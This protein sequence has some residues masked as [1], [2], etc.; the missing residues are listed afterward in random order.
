V[1]TLVRQLKACES[2]VILKI[3]D[4]AATNETQLYRSTYFDLKLCRIDAKGKSQCLTI[5]RSSRMSLRKSAMAAL[6]A[7]SLVVVPSVAFAAQGSAASKLSV[8]SA[9]AVQK[10][11]RAK[12]V[13]G[14]QNEFGGSIALAVAAAVAVIVGIV[15]AAD[16]S[17][18]P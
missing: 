10:A 4:C 6:A 17:S 18:S 9:P 14:E 7:A 8:R 13:R 11:V 15:I 5:N 3:I 1:I 2:Q 12:A 16:G